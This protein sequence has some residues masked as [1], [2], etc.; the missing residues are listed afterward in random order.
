MEGYPGI[1]QSQYVDDVLRFLVLLNISY[2]SVRY[3]FFRIKYEYFCVIS[4]YVFDKN[5]SEFC[6]MSVDY[7][8]EIDRIHIFSSGCSIERTVF[9]L[10]NRFYLRHSLKNKMVSD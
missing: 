10:A 9:R 7:I 6:L 5:S 8:I 3:I 4:W 2:Y 1:Y